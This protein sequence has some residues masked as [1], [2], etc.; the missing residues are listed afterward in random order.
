MEGCVGENA[1]RVASVGALAVGVM[2]A[3]SRASFA[4]GSGAGAPEL[5]SLQS[6]SCS[7]SRAKT[8]IATPRASLPIRSVSSAVS[9]CSVVATCWLG[10]ANDGAAHDAVGDAAKSMRV[11]RAYLQMSGA[12]EG[13]AMSLAEAQQKLL[14]APKAPSFAILHPTYEGVCQGNRKTCSCGQPFFS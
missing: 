4:N 7:T 12:E 8:S 11:Y 1:A 14:S 2:S 10:V 5:R 3:A 13:A 6:I 9:C